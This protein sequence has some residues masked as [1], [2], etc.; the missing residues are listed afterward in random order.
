MAEQLS[1]AE[2]K[3][4]RQEKFEAWLAMND[5]LLD[6]EFLAGD[7]P[8]MPDDPYSRAGLVVAEA[9]ALER[10]ANAEEAL[11]PDSID[12]YWKLVRF[13][14]ETFVRTLGYEWTCVPNHSDDQGES[15]IA[16][17]FPGDDLQLQ[18][19]G[20]VTTVI[21]P[22]R[23]RKGGRWA[24]V[25]DNMAEDTAKIRAGIP[26]YPPIPEDIDEDDL[27]TDPDDPTLRTDQS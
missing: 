19:P 15:W 8:G 24:W 16:V 18:L 6:C 22:E 4:Q 17:Q 10:W 13:V 21:S 12:M 14:G 3:R 5:Y 7:V 20:L 23:G 27:I 9:N 11:A 1:V 2:L 25:W 26:L